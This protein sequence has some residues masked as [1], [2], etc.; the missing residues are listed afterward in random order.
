M[1]WAEW[2][3]ASA[4]RMPA[5]LVEYTS[6]H[7]FCILDWMLTQ[8]KASTKPEQEEQISEKLNGQD[9]G[10]MCPI[11][12]AAS[13]ISYCIVQLGGT[14]TNQATYICIRARLQYSYIGAMLMDGL[15]W[16]AG[17]VVQPYTWSL[18]PIRRS[19]CATHREQE[20]EI[21]SGMLLLRSALCA[22]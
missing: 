12:R 20:R 9:L 22:I 15:V 4:R 7:G 6:S 5:T 11:L 3:M 1:K 17:I 13:G 2:S 19:V 14:S 18:H 8:L 10:I 16:Q 21:D